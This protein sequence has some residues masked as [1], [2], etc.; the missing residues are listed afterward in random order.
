MICAFCHLEKC[1]L[2]AINYMCL[3]YY[4]KLKLFWQGHVHFLN[5]CLSSQSASFFV[6]IRSLLTVTHTPSF[7]FLFCFFHLNLTFRALYSMTPCLFGSL[8]SNTPTVL[9][10]RYVVRLHTCR[11]ILPIAL[12]IK[13]HR[14]QDNYHTINTVHDALLN[15]YC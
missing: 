2:H 8:W 11:G 10:G 4:S 6:L 15:C 9:G 14:Q 1:I 12:Y 7:F 13:P 3:H 5:F